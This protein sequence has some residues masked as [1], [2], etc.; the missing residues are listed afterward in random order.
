MG[1]DPTVKEAT[2]FRFSKPDKSTIQ[3]FIESQSALDVT[4]SGIGSTQGTPSSGYVVDH[5]KAKIGE[6]DIS[7]IDCFPTATSV[8][9]I[10]DTPE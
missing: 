6:A 5:T 8:C 1:G 3:S 4:Y 7:Q 10:D 2:M 9:W